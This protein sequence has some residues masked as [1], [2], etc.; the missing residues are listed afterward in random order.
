MN[1]PEVRQLCAAYLDGELTPAE[2]AALDA[3]LAKCE[4]CAAELELEREVAAALREG[5]VSLAA[6][7]GFARSVT[8]A[9][10]ARQRGRL[11]LTRGRPPVN[12]RRAGCRS[13]PARPSPG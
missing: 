8:A 13:F 2:A 12:A 5:A 6:P 11:L 1:C 7:E 9:L 3:H 4:S 10:A